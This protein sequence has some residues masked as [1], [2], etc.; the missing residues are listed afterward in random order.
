[1]PATVQSNL[2]LDKGLFYLYMR[3]QNP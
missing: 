3:P 2:S 1:V